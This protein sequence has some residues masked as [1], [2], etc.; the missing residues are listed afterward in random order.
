LPPSQAEGSSN[1]PRIDNDR[2]FRDVPK[3]VVT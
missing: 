3:N 2:P 1:H